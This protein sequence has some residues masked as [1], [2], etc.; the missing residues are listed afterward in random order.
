M[1]PIVLAVVSDV[2]CGSTV[3][4]V[5]PEGVLLDDGGKYLPSKASLWLWENWCAYWD[6]VKAHVTEVGGELWNVF[7]GDLVE[8]DHHGT[9][10][11]VSKNP[12]PQNYLTHR[13]FG[14]AQALQPKHTFIVRGTE[15]HVGPAGAT[16]EA[17]AR[18]LKAEANP[19]T[20]KW[21]WW[22]L[23]LTPHGCLMDFQHHPTARGSL[24]WTGPQMAQRMAFRIWT[25]HKLRDLPA[26][27]LAIRSHLHVTRDS[28][29]AYPTRAIIT[30]A[31][32]LKTAHAHKVASDSIADVGG[33]IVT[34]MPDSTYTVRTILYTPE[35]PAPWSPPTTF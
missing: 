29:D 20:R 10:Q 21:S 30:P 3:A 12:E 28:G 24:P 16:E 19:E 2:H 27:K 1:K 13:V 32:Q 7:N 8:G 18:S 25:E 6:V 35:L 34:V 11:I 5:P 4:A 15:A 14:V 26:P 23:R 31:W 9:T 33:L 17:F 22:H